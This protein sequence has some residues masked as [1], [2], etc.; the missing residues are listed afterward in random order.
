MA[1]VEPGTG[2]AHI[3]NLG[4][5]MHITIPTKKRAFILL[6]MPFW[7]AGWTAGMIMVPTHMDKATTSGQQLFMVVWLVLWAVGGIMA[8]AMFLWTLAGRE[9]ISATGQY[10]T[11]EKSL[12]GLKT[13]Q[14]YDRSRI[15]KCRVILGADTGS[16]V[17]NRT[18]SWGFTG[19]TIAFD[20]G[21]KT[22]N[23]GIFLEEAEA[24]YVIDELKRHGYIRGEAT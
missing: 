4:S 20:Y 2:R 8:L 19:G 12:F 16:I 21:L 24:R 3:E 5:E 6:F 7:L 11:V 22:V 1:L 14:Q 23:F 17:G 13:R 9:I 18:F 15:E 10:L